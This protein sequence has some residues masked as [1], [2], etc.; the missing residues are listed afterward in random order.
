MSFRDIEINKKYRSNNSSNIAKDF[1]SKVLTESYIYKRAVGFFSSSSL[2][3]TSRGIVDIYKKHIPGSEA[4]IKFIVSPRLSNEDVEAVKKGYK[5]RE[6]IISNALTRDF[7]DA[8]EEFELERLNMLAHLISSGTLD[9]KV[10]VTEFENDD[11]GMYHEKIGIFKDE[12]GNKICFSGS[13][14]ESANAFNNNFESI[15]VFKSWKNPEYA[16]EIEEDFDLMWDNKTKNITIYSFPDAVKER[17]FKYK[18]DSFN[19]N[20]DSEEAIKRAQLAINVPRISVNLY[21][22][23]KKAIQEWFKNRCMGIFDMATGTGKTFTAY[24]AMVKL[25]ERKK[26]KLATIIVCPYQHLVEQWVED[27]EK[28][29]IRNP[30]IGYT[31]SKYSNY[32]TKLKK[33]IQDY[34]DGVISYFYF[35]TTNASYKTLKVQEALSQLNANVLFIADEAHNMGSQGMR[36]ALFH[37]F[38]YR[39]ALSATVDRYRDEEGTDVIYS[40][41]GKKCIEYGLKRAIKEKKLS[42]YFYHPIVVYLSDEEAQEYAEL[43]AQLSKYITKDKF[44]KLKLSK[45]GEFIA[46]KRARIIAGAKNKTEALRREMKNHLN[47][48]NMLV[49]CGTGKITSDNDEEVRQID[50]VCKILGNDLRLKIGRYTSRESVEERALIKDRFKN[51]NDLQALIAIKCLDEGVNIP[52]IK[53]AFILASSTNP[54]EYIQRRGRI[55]RLSKSKKH[56]VIYDFVTMP[57]HFEDLSNYDESVIKSFQTLAKN[58]I[59]RIVEFASSASNSSEADSLIMKIIENY[60]LDK[61]D[62]GDFERIEWSDNDE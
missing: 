50:E 34:N 44:D 27:A 3:Y 9:I 10:A 40:Y 43:T 52:S 41:F 36:K 35:F 57:L 7:Y 47:E 29:N 56:S 15:V 23:Q 32:L 1:L 21:D 45:S 4:S 20:I 19:E 39:I 22:Y 18:K 26:Y 60:K 31:L 61:F 58:E 55:L 11:I 12:K 38:K 51:S 5:T 49:Y 16:V 59:N 17:L 30:I 6:E 24:G 54:R 62:S 42:E 37:K 2:I 53:T 46:L 33:A 48:Y 14:N 28:F 25:L 13:L 8:S